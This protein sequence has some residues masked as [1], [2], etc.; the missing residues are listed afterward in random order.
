MH[1]AANDFKSLDGAEFRKDDPLYLAWKRNG[2]GV[3]S[4]N[5]SALA[6]IHKSSAE[7][8]LPDLFCFALIADFHGYYPAYSKVFKERHQCLTW[9][10]LKAHTLNRGGEV[11]LKSADPRA[12]PRIN[13]HYFE[14]GTDQAGRDL[15]AVV[16]G[17]RFV[18]TLTRDLRFLTEEIPGPTVSSDDDLRAFVRDN[19]WGHHASC[20]CKIGPESD[21]GVLDSSFRVH[22]VTGLRVVDASIFPKIPGFFIVSSIYIAAE[23]AADVIH[24]AARV[25]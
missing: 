22:G 24:A 9:A 18:R 1:R 14:E 21:N 12:A 15:D 8:P 5:G 20:T 10:V 13:F 2:G 3:Y 17:I 16:A 19:A 23:K 25:S 4:T 11:T 6:V 7:Q